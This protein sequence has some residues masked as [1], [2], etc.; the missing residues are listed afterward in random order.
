MKTGY[1][2]I[3]RLL[4]GVAIL[5]GCGKGKDTATPPPLPAA[6]FSYT[7]LTVDGAPRG[8]VY[9]GAGVRPVIRFRFS[10]KAD[11]STVPAACAFSSRTGTAIPF[12]VTYENGDSTVVLQP[13]SPLAYITRYQVSISTALQSVK[14]EPLLSGITLQLTT[15]IDST[16]KFPRLSDDALLTL[17]Q[18]RT[19]QYFW[20][21]AHPVSGLARER[22]TS[23]E[24]V[25]TGGS[26]F[27]LMVLVAGI[28]RGFI[29]RAAGLARMQQIVGFL[30]HKAVK[31]QGAFPHWLHGTTGQVIPFSA[32]D[33]GADLVET[34]FLVQGLLTVRQY[35]NGNDPTETGLRKDINA[36]C[37]SVQWNRFQKDGANVLYWHRSPDYNWEMNLP[38]RGWNE[39]LITYVLAA[40]SRTYPIT[41]AVYDEGWA[42]KGNIRHNGRY[43]GLALPLGPA[44]GGPLFFSQ[45]SFLGLNP[46]GLTDAYADYQ[47]QVLHHTQINYQYCVAN[48]K[49]MYGY[50][51]DCWG[52][53]ASDN[54]NGYTASSPL[55]DVGV[56]APTAALSA[57]P[58]T[59]A[60]SLRAL[61]FFYYKLG[62]R[63]WKT[64]GFTDA[65]SLQQAWFADSFL[66]IDQGPAMI[67]MENYR[68]GLL[69]QLF[70]SC[71]EIKSG[72]HRLGFQSPHV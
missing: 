9:E 54:P 52:L 72:L 8:F 14:K 11:R 53:T 61:H 4:L 25:T 63:I 27:G 46:M 66:A 48:P 21:F 65:F 12:S 23:G 7:A 15:Q 34:A 40:S 59:P 35:F 36:L 50:S 26:G 17:V 30:Q 42:D 41:K 19:F 38:V 5:A 69:W 62:D 10:G 6:T 60:A 18:Q 39:A 55:N 3:T 37:D 24:T 33:N 2:M 32:K 44:F 28:H 68:S 70:M 45:Y 58:Y 56:I 13:V 43:Y 51:S 49:G 64:Y 31:Y 29:T 22:N 16:D 47:T 20:D 67:M 57:M 1:P 71:P